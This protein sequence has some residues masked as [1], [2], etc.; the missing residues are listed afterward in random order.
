MDLRAIFSPGRTLDSVAYVALSWAIGAVVFWVVFVLVALA[1]PLMIVAL[2][3]LPLLWLAF[4][5]SHAVALGERRR[6]RALLGAE[7]PVRPLPRRIFAS[8]RARG[9]WVEACLSGGAPPLLRLGG[10]VVRVRAVG[11]PPGP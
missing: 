11:G 5:V 4:A 3:G 2:A 1:L 10:G 7:F 8:V 9:S 6:A